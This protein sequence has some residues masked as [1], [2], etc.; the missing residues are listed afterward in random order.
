M[1]PLSSQLVFKFDKGLLP[2]GNVRERQRQKRSKSKRYKI[3]LTG[4]SN[5]RNVLAS[6]R[7]IENENVIANTSF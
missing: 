2:K 3:G 1:L 5:K 7:E 6:Q 4:K